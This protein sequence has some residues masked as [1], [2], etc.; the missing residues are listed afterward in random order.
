MSSQCCNQHLT[1]ETSG[2][3][4][5]VSEFLS[6]IV[7]TDRNCPTHIIMENRRQNKFDVDVKLRGY[8]KVLE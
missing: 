2:E 4:V 7:A 8:F 5:P 3:G 6:T 1:R